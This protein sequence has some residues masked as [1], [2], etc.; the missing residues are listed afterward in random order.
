MD[1]STLMDKFIQMVDNAE[2]KYGSFEVE[3]NREAAKV[4]DLSK[5][6]DAMIHAQQKSQTPAERFMRKQLLKG[7][8]K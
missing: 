6:L 7:L 2:I 5:I 1:A 3:A 4:G 8:G